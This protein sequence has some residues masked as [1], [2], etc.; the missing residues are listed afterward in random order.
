MDTQWQTLLSEKSKWTLTLKLDDQRSVFFTDDGKVLSA[1]DLMELNEEF[2]SH[3]TDFELSPIFWDVSFKY[4]YLDDS[5]EKIDILLV[6][7]NKRQSF[8]IAPPNFL[9]TDYFVLAHKVIPIRNN[10]Y[11]A[12][13][14]FLP[15]LDHDGIPGF[16]VKE[17]M[18]FDYF[19]ASNKFF[20]VKSG[21]S[22]QCLSFPAWPVWTSIVLHPAFFPIAISR[23]SSPMT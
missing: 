13:R 1:E 11:L 22:L 12:L 21:F 17:L 16:T 10:D 4:Y 20:A 15:T 5:N 19:A 7:T 2:S 14:Q 3:F 18:N 23:V 6:L 9:D 8:E